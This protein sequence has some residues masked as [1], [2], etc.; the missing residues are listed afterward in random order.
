MALATP[1]GTASTMTSSI[2]YKEPT[3]APA[4]PAEA[5]EAR[6]SVFISSALLHC[7]RSAPR[8]R[9]SCAQRRTASGKLACWAFLYH[10]STRASASSASATVLPSSEKSSAS[11]SRTR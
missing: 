6:E 10:T 11:I 8:A 4:S 7:R 9:S 3:S 1:T 5:G 2:M